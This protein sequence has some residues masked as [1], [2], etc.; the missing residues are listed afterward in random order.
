MKR[1]QRMGAGIL[2]NPLVTMA[3]FG[4]VALA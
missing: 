4:L 2:V 3:T 1:K